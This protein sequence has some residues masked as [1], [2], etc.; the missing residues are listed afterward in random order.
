M[1][2]CIFWLKL[3][4][5]L[6]CFEHAVDEAAA[7]L[8]CALSSL[9]VSALL[10]TQITYSAIGCNQSVDLQAVLQVV[11]LALQLGAAPGKPSIEA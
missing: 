11:S 7:S 6:G 4:L 5:Q 3:L 1:F 8:Y 2:E 9:G 10:E